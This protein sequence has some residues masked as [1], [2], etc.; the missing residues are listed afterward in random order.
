ML[1]LIEKFD[2]KIILFNVQTLIL[3]F[4]NKSNIIVDEILNIEIEQL[5]TKFFQLN[6]YL[7]ITIFYL[8]ILIYKIFN[9]IIIYL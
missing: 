4:V 2:Y 8:I 3:Y 1:T 6:N 9:S 5:P 7:F